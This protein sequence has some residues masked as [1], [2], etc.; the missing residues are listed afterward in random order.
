MPHIEPILFSGDETL[1]LRQLDELNKL[2]KG[3]SFRWFKS[4]ADIMIEGRDFYYLPADDHAEFIE[5][6][7]RAGQIYA[8]S[9][10]AVLL[11]RSGYQQ[12]RARSQG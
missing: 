11:T 2:P 1:S 7:K 12:M 5:Q 9:R 6:L 10:H 3:S 4:C 8:S